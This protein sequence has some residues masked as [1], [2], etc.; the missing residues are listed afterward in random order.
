MRFKNL[1]LTLVL[2]VTII[3][4]KDESKNQDKT[5]QETE[6]LPDAFRVT[7]D[8]VTK[9]NDD[10]C[11]L[12][13]Q[14]GSINFK[15]GVW[16]AVKGSNNS[17]K[18]VFT[19]PEGVKPTQLRIDFGMNKEQE[20]IILNSVTMDYLGKS[21]TIGCPELVAFFRADDSKCTFDHVTGL[22]KAVVKDGVRQ[23]PSLYPHESN[24]MP[25]IQK[26]LN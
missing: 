7:L 14:D 18:V 5:A 21:R 2:A 10:F 1:F 15:D 25:A 12:Y 19:L 24:M 26:I 8:V 22:I 9:K 11:V 17:Q 23:N 20:D 16:Q 6:V 4:C 3:G 13:T